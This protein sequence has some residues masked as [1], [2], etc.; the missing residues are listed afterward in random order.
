MSFKSTSDFRDR[1]D[2]DFSFDLDRLLKNEGRI[3]TVFTQSGGKSGCGFTGLLLEANRCFIK[4]MTEF[5]SRPSDPFGLDIDRRDR[6][7]RRCDRLGTIIVIPVDKIVALVFN[8][9]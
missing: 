9:I 7:H 4:L 1:T 2:T 3:I 6:C 5:P 8:E